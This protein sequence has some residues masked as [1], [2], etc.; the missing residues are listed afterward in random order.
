MINI[1]EKY[2]PFWRR[3]VRD[4]AKAVWND[5]EDDDARELFNG[6]ARIFSKRYR[7]ALERHY[8]AR[9]MR[10]YRGTIDGKVYEWLTNQYA[11]R[12][13]LKEMVSQRQSEIVARE[14]ERLQKQES[15][16]AQEALNKVYKAKEG[17]NVYKVFSFGDH[18]KDRSEQIGEENAFALGTAVNEGI[19]KEF[20]D[21][22]IWTTQRDRSVRKTHR[23][24]DKKC[25][26]FADPPTEVL[27]SG[28]EHTGNCGTAWG[29]RCYAV[30]PIKPTKPLRGYK[31]YER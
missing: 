22:Y 1:F 31:V 25:F 21:R 4:F 18:Y 23:K 10:V 9:G 15:Y 11:L 20:S 13:S 6:R 12:D 24:L 14:I 27:K 8:A 5:E 26:L 16:T 3:A 17:E 29:C 2:A 7:N 28:K 19:I 30:I